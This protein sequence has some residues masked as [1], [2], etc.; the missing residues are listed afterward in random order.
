MQ[1]VVNLGLNS[2]K[3]RYFYSRLSYLENLIPAR[4]SCAALQKPSANP[5]CQVKLS[6][7]DMALLTQ[8]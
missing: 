5:E 2:M 1:I 3:C 8:Q 7:Y 4:L 6:M